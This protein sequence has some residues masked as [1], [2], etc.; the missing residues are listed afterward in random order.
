MMSD[1]ASRRRHR[2]G[3]C[4]GQF[5]ALPHHYFLTPEFAVL[6][7]RAIKLLIELGL[8]Y[9]GNNNG[10]LCATW[11][12][13]RRRGFTSADQLQKARDELIDRGWIIVSRQGGRRA[14]SLYALTFHTVDHCGGKIDIAKGPA[15]H[16][17][18]PENAHLRE[19][20][21]VRVRKSERRM[22]AAA[23]KHN[24]NRNTEHSDPQCGAKLNRAADHR[25]QS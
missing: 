12:I 23:A 15:R 7:G 24:S 22:Y 3:P 13:M 18:K 25:S 20:R 4:L 2:N 1:R 19:L 16:L 6:S 17:W 8:Q 14:P 5:L 21:P 11:S 10:D 9:S